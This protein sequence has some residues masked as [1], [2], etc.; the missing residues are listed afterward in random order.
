MSERTSHTVV[1]QDTY[2]DGDNHTEEYKE[3]DRQTNSQTYCSCGKEDN[4]ARVYVPSLTIVC[5]TRIIISYDVLI[6][7]ASVLV[8][9]I[10]TVIR[11]ITFIGAT[12]AL[13]TVT[14]KLVAIAGTCE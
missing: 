3:E 12:D 6:T 2:G 14:L 13:P 7:S 4:Y 9:T 8:T 11:S 10:V 1:Y 5:R